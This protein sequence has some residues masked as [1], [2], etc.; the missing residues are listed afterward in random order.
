LRLVEFLLRAKKISPKMK[1]FPVRGGEEVR[2]NMVQS[3]ETF[4]LIKTKS[5]SVTFGGP[6]REPETPPGEKEVRVSIAKD[7]LFQLYALVWTCPQK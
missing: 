1:A 5:V 6:Q 7:A 3:A 2:L 4:S